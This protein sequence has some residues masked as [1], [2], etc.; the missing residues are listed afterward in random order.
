MREI[1]FQA[2]LKGESTLREVVGIDWNML[3]VMVSI[4][5]CMEWHDWKVLRQLTGLT[6]QNGKDIYEGH[7][8]NWRGIEKGKIVF[9]NGCFMC[10]PYTDREANPLYSMSDDIIVKDT[11]P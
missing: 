5:G 6:D 7:E 10:K 2:I 1:K 11:N 4:S 3:K 8:Y 9:E